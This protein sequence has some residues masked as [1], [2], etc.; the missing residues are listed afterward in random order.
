MKKPKWAKS[1][2]KKDLKHI[3]DVSPTGRPSLRVAKEN[4]NNPLCLECRCIG[5]SLKLAGVIP[6]EKKA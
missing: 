1:L 3:A 6:L 5:T 2:S 4:A